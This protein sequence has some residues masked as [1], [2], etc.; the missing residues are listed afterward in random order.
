MND[1][2][3]S[4]C[5]DPVDERE[6]VGDPIGQKEFNVSGFCNRCQHLEFGDGDQEDE[7]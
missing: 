4:Y 5:G 2:F 6:F 1:Q 3:C 7:K